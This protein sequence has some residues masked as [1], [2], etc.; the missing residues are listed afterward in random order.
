LS[1][2]K[3]ISDHGANRLGAS[4]LDARVW[5]TVFYITLH[6]RQLSAQAQPNAD[7]IK[8]A[9]ENLNKRKGSF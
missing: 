2:E 6:D 1:S 5:L 8:S 7:K 9:G 3:R 4:A